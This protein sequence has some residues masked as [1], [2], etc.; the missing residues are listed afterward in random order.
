MPLLTYEATTT[1]FWFA[2]N[3][4]PARPYRAIKVL[5]TGERQLR[6]VTK[7]DFPSGSNLSL[8]ISPDGR[9]ALIT[10]PDQRGTDLFLVDGFR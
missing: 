8:S 2:A 4:T 10:R 3:P 6:E 1:G 7:M 9:Y 5:R